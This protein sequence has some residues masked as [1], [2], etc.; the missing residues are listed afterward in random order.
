MITDSL[1]EP[2]TYAATIAKL[3]ESLARLSERSNS[4]KEV[5][6]GCSDESSLTRTLMPCLV[7]LHKIYR[8]I[9]A[10]VRALRQRF[11]DGADCLL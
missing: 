8:Q 11:L 7:V 3:N 9:D 1:N 5:V 4:N 6:G 10:F 2:A